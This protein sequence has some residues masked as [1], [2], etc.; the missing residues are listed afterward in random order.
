MTAN[1]NRY[2]KKSLRLRNHDYSQGNYFITI[3]T[4][5]RIPFF[6]EV[7][8]QQMHLS[9]IGQIAHEYWVD[10]PNHFPHV[11]LDAHIVMPD[12]MHG[13]IA[14]ERPADRADIPV[15]AIH[16]S[17]LLREQ[18][19]V[20]DESITR[21]MSALSPKAGSL[22]VIIRSYKAAVTRW[23]GQSGYPDFRWQSRFYDCI[24]RTQDSCNRI[25]YYIIY[26]PRKWE[27]K[28]SQAAALLM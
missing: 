10:I 8:S 15:G 11:T 3:C 24:I 25:R 22:A 12:H 14:I 28:R 2:G 9:A 19:A 16:G 21:A 1:K 23:C 5:D 18:G 17:S 27:R 6:G 4:H 26:N 7:R 20:W 13:M